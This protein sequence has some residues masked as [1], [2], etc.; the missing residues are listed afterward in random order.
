MSTRGVRRV[1]AG[2]P[3]SSAPRERLAKGAEQRARAQHLTCNQC[4][5]SQVPSGVLGP[6][7]AWQATWTQKLSRNPVRS[8]LAPPTRRAH[9]RPHAPTLAPTLATYTRCLAS[10]LI[11]LSH[12]PAC[13]FRAPG[14][15]RRARRAGPGGFHS[16][17][18]AHPT[19]RC[20]RTPSIP[21]PLEH[22]GAPVSQDGYLARSACRCCFC[23]QSW[24]L[25]FTH[26]RSSSGSG[27]RARARALWRPLC[28]QRLCGRRRR[29]TSVPR[30][31]LG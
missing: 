31:T 26:Q 3:H 8:L 21:S 28:S 24:V 2:R 11:C 14:P 1:L 13:C 17:A 5:L 15:L 9:T 4:R 18:A 16:R 22:L 19:R 27:A 23:L 30:T 12:S 20:R 10:P 25:P 29:L 6:P 7:C